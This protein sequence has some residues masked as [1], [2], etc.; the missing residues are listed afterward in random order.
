MKEA[1]IAQT[2]LATGVSR[3][4]SLWNKKLWNEEGSPKISKAKVVL[5]KE[6]SQ[7]I[8]VLLFQY[9]IASPKTT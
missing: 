3:K 8:G 5:V 7:N 9:N 1:H 4:K 6:N 2:A